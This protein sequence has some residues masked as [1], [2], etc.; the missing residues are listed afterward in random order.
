MSA[1]EKI[2]DAGFTL[3]LTDSGNLRINPTSKLT[4][5]QRDYIKSHKT[6][7]IAEL[8][9]ETHLGANPETYPKL[10]DCYTPNGGLIRLTAQD[11][12]TEAYLLR[13]NPKPP[14]VSP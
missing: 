1:L 6:E 14:S 2:K 13:M 11:A 3:S 5:A 8:E 9:A 4:D 7:I 10:V 12:K